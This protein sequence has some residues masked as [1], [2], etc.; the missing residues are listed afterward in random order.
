MPEKD[1][2]KLLKLELGRLEWEFSLLYE[3]S[4]AMRSTLKLDQIFYIIL[5]ALTSHEG[6]GFNRAM[7]FLV[8]DKETVLD[9]VMG[10]GPH[11]AE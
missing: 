8:N 1:E 9:G 11:S 10:I 3:V 6:L 4:N 2:V 7:L 5:T